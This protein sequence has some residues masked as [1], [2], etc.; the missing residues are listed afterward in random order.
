MASSSVSLRSCFM[1]HSRIS[2]S[3]FWLSAR[4]SGVA[5]STSGL[6]IGS[7]CGFTNA[8]AA[9]TA[10]CEWMSMV[11][12]GGRASR[13]GLPC[14]R[15]AVRSYLFH[16][17]IGSSAS[18]FACRWDHRQQQIDPPRLLKW[19]G[20]A[21]EVAGG[22][23]RGSS[24]RNGPQPV[25]SFL[26]FDSLPPLGP[27]RRSPCRGS[28]ARCDGPSAR[29]SRSARFRYRA[30]PPGFLERLLLIMRV[31]GR[32][33]LTAS[34]RACDARRSQP[35]PI[36]VCGSIAPWNTTSFRSGPNTRN[37]ANR[38]ASLLEDETKS[39]S[40]EGP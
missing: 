34:C 13:P 23:S 11:M 4:V 9:G 27:D 2:S 20:G 15:A 3:C 33:G 12:L 36:G 26:K 1:M 6:V 38:S 24:C 19:A 32:Y 37:T 31:V 28:R 16:C 39:L 25:S 14:R 21:A 22:R 18:W 29:R 40:A 35:C 10:T 8:A 30:R 5:C 7:K 17:V